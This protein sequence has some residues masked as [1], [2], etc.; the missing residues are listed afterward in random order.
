MELTDLQ[1]QSGI[2]RKDENV[3]E[4]II[5]K[6]GKQVYYVAGNIM[7]G[8]GSKEDIEECAA[9]AFFKAWNTIDS[10]N[11]E[12]SG[13]KTWLLIITKYMA[14]DYRRRILKLSTVNIDDLRLEQPEY[15]VSERVIGRLEQE[16][17]IGVI[18]GFGNVDKELFIRRYFYGEKINDLADSLRLSRS[19]ID[20]RLLRGRKIIK[21][22]FSYE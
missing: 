4:Y 10:Y 14:L 12:K 19:A 20:N 2:K 21:E 11:P 8:C 5:E 3:Y 17:L 1:I 16:R 13:F 18:N 15:D 9:D 6:Y 22:A 7:R